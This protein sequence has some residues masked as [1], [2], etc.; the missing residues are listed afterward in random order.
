[1]L[2]Y[3]KPSVCLFY[4]SPCLVANLKNQLSELFD[5]DEY[6]PYGS[7]LIWLDSIIVADYS[8]IPKAIWGKFIDNRFSLKNWHTL[9]NSSEYERDIVADKLKIPE[10]VWCEYFNPLFEHRNWLV[11]LNSA[12]EY[13][14]PMDKHVVRSK[15]ED[16]ILTLR[17]LYRCC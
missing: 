13:E 4:C 2:K 10:D 14:L 12:D 11:L 5:F 17:D 8:N 9:L 3:K 16:I 7:D 6:S 15:A 1:M